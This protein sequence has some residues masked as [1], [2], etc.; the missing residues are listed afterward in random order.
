MHKL[1][2]ALIPLTLVLACSAA[3]ADPCETLKSQIEAKIAASGVSGFTL[4]IV[5]TGSTAAGRVVGTCGQGSKK[6]LYS[7]GVRTGSG[8]TTTPANA[9]PAAA[10]AASA[11]RPAPSAASSAR[12]VV[13]PKKKPLVWTECKDG[14]LT[15]NETC[16]H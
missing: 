13:K 12:P 4:T 3:H 14:S 7:G 11:A 6:I 10:T 8:H 2:L 1:K 5:D 15:L 9:A 16:N